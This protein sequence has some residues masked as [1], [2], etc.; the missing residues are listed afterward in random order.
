MRRG[1]REEPCVCVAERSA[2]QPRRP[3]STPG[4]NADTAKEGERLAALCSRA[5]RCSAPGAVIEIAAQLLSEEVQTDEDEPGGDEKESRHLFAP[6]SNV[7][8]GSWSI[9]RLFWAVNT[10]MVHLFGLAEAPV[11][12]L[13]LNRP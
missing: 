10:I 1:R 9:E 11:G 8:F 3:M 6:R 4:L 12:P 5:L 2:D 7:C 13:A